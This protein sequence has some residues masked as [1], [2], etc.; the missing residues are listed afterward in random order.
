MSI[1]P[2]SQTPVT[3]AVLDAANARADR[4]RQRYDAATDRAERAEA[5]LDRVR[6][7]LNHSYLHPTK[8]DLWGAVHAALEAS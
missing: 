7:T 3:Q 8:V 4:W 2:K 1:Y 5:A 6:H